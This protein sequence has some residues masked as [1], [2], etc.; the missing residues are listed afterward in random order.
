M[1]GNLRSYEGS[2][3][4][5]FRRLEREMDHMFDNVPWRGGIRAVAHGYPPL[6]VGVTPDQVDVYLFA[7][8]IDPKLLEITLHQ[9]LL[10]I[11]GE[12]KLDREVG[13]QYYRRERID[14]DFH[15]AVNLPEDADPEQVEAT[16][17][18]GVLH[19]AIRRR[20]AAKPRQ[21]EVN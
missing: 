9:N 4:D 3:F 20:K 21:I 1:F 14:G 2:L 6:N 18:E 10:T 8:G 16:Y 15:R 12:R 7:P 17:S 19:V 5:D 13:I 11:K